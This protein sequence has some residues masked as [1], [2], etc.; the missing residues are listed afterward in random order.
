LVPYFLASILGIVAVNWSV[1]RKKRVSFVIN[2]VPL[3]AKRGREKLHI[4]SV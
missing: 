1:W 3:L 2:N 4:T